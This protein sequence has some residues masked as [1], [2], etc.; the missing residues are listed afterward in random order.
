MVKCGNCKRVGH[1]T[2]DCKAIVVAT[3]QRAP[4]RNQKGNTCYEYGRQGHY[5]NECPKLRNQNYGNKMGD[6]TRNNKAKARAYAIRRGGANSNSNVITDT[7]Y[8][9]ELADGRISKTNVILRGCALG[10]LGHPFDIDMKLVELGSFDFVIGMDWLAKY[11]A[12]IICD[13]KIVRIPYGDEMLIIQGDGCNGGSKSK[14]RII[15]YTKTHKPSSSPWGAPILFVKKKDGSFRMCIDYSELNRLTVKNQYPLLRNDDLFD[16]LQGSRVHSKIDL[17]SGY[18]QLKVREEDILKTAFRTRYGHYE[19]QVMP[20]VLTNALVI[21][22]DLM[23]RV[24]KA[25]LD[26]F[27]IVFIDNILI[28]S[29]NKKEHEGHLKLIFTLLKEE[30]LFIKFSKCEFRLSKVKFLSHL[31]DSEAIHVDPAKIETVKDWASPKTLTEIR[32]ENFVVYCDASH[33]GL[34]V[35]LM[36]REKVIAY[37]SRQLKVHEKNYTT[38]RLRAWRS[39]VFLED[40]EAVSVWYEENITMDFVTKLP[41]TATGQDMIWVIVDHLTKTVHFLCMREDG[42]MEKLMRQ[43]LKEVVSRHG[44]PVSIISDRDGRLHHLRRCMG[45]NVDRLSSGLRLEIVSS[46]AQRSSMRLMRRLFKSKAVFRPHDRQKSYADV[47]RKPI[48]FQVGD[49][50]ILKVSPWKGVIHFGKREKPNLCYIGTFKIL[51]K[52][53]TVAYRLELPEQLS[54]VHCTFYVSNMKK[55]LP[56]E[57]LAIPLNKIQIDDKLHFIEEPVEIMDRDVKHLKQSLILIVKVRW[58][59]RKG[60][61]FTWE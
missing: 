43:Y 18:H 27:V 54:R 35:V 12:V 15:S 23:N 2:R 30:E 39:S 5:R 44:V 53:G 34:G 3:T 40:V 58:N 51:A 55:C 10:L 20:F 32:S 7:S 37:A 47:R 17:R 49:K 19:F 50:V 24:C 33:Q 31:I 25:Y 41:K 59:S 60:P 42:S 61:E 13:E 9:I 1:M 6:K 28:Y 11:H 26:K 46:L 21:F 57:T 52:V 48:E 45:V 8:A 29:K 38:P 22:M 56:D 4:V 36:L 16:Q 14:L